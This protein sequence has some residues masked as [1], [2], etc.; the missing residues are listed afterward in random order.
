MSAGEDAELVEIDDAPR[1]PSMVCWKEASN[2]SSGRLLLGDEAENTAILSPQCLERCPKR[3]F[4]QEFMLLGSERV[5]VTDAI[6]AIFLHVLAEASPRR[7]GQPPRELRLTHPARWGEKR[8]AKLREAGAAAGF[9]QPLLLPEPVGAA[10]YFA[11]EQLSPGDYVAVYDLGGGTFDTAVLQRTRDGFE[12]VGKPGGRD[13]LGGEDFDYRLY[14]FLGQRLDAEQWDTLISPD[15]D[16]FWQRAHYDFRKDVRRA[17]ERLSRSSEATVRTPVPGQ[18]DMPVMVSEFE[19]LIK[20]DID[21]TVQELEQTISSNIRVADLSAIYLAGGSSR[22]PLVSRHIEERLG[23]TPS[24]LGDPKG[25]IALGATRA[26]L[27]SPAAP[28]PPPPPPPR[29]TGEAP[30]DGPQTGDTAGVTVTPRFGL[31]AKRN[32]LLGRAGVLLVGSSILSAV[33]SVFALL[34]LIRTH[35]YTGFKLGNVVEVAGWVMF[36]L[37]FAFASAAFFGGDRTR[38]RRLRTAGLIAACASAALVVGFV[39]FAAVDSAHHYSAKLVV[40]SAVLAAAYVALTA[41]ALATSSAFRIATAATANGRVK[42]DS[43]LG[44]AAVA[45]AIWLITAGVAEIFF[46]MGESDA[47]ARGGLVTGPGI[48]AGGHVIGMLGAIAAA[49]A[50]FRV[51]RRR[52]GEQVYSVGRRDGHLGIAAAVLALGFLLIAIGLAVY[53]KAV[54][55]HESDVMLSN[56]VGACSELAVA[57]AALTAAMGFFRTRRSWTQKE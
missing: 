52:R 18:P 2:G 35:G 1:M 46:L 11:K 16:E 45:L 20:D 22:I 7:G 24:V 48:N 13:E 10:V 21:A 15:S 28:P 41:G 31:F 54:P 19:A 33:S 30:A 3:K 6:G 12:V 17:K 26:H 5:R 8:L 32:R 27:P 39:V 55:A 40:S 29:P 43:R 42:R 36:A 49:V 34:E 37:A 44:W 50:F 9:E 4:G 57:A 38:S 23:M 25:V 56:W 14:R 53:A 51:G 47:G